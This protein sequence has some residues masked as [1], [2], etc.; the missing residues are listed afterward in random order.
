MSPDQAGLLGLLVAW[1]VGIG[2]AAFALQRLVQRASIVV[3]IALVVLAA[4]GV[5]VAGVLSGSRAMLLSDR[6]DQT[7]WWVV[8]VATALAVV[9]A[10]AL[11][12]SVARYTSRLTHDARLIGQGETVS[13]GPRGSAE[14]AALAR[15]LRETSEQLDLAR[16][17]QARAERARRELISWISHDLRTPLA[18]IKAMTEALQDGVVRDGAAYHRK[19]LA[20]TDQMTGL[21]NDLLELST[22]ESG[23]LTLHAQRLDLYDLVSDAMADLAELAR[24]QRLVVDGAS[25]ASAVIDADGALLGRVIRNLIVN[26]MTYSPAGSTV[27]VVTRDLG[28]AALLEVGDECGGIDVRDVPRLFEAGWRGSAERT[29]T[30]YTGAGIGLS[31]VAGIVRAHGGSVSVRNDGPGCVFS[32]TLPRPEPAVDAPGGDAQA[33][34]GA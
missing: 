18:S 34:S 29:T 14:L 24:S 3:Q 1:A 32:V 23:T 30:P 15:A 16:S 20:Q 17:S 12:T 11:G 2:V 31:T 26:A 7:L 4:V 21:V 8:L 6:A 27:R 10:L 33:R 25:T 5:V 22:I 28:T 13:T 9:L 19:I